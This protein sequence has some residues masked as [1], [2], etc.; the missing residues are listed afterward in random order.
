MRLA[1]RND[2]DAVVGCIASAYAVYQDTIPDLPPVLDGIDD[3]IA[4]RRVSVLTKVGAV[5][6][7][8]IVQM[9]DG[10]AMLENVA[11]DP[12][13]AGQGLG[14][15]LIDHAVDLARGRGCRRIRLNTHAGMARNIALYE[16]L[17]WVVTDRQGNSVSMARDLTI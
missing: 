1:T 16:H 14:R 2:L 11:V 9:E 12:A 7:V 17:G 3:A 15:R 13:F 5:A 6:G 10:D 4:A 8:L